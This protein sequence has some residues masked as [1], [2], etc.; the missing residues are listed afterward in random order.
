MKRWSTFA[1]LVF[2]LHFAWEMS[3]AAW[4]ASMRG[5]TF[6]R[7][8]FACARAALGDL[9]IVTI[10]F[11]VAAAVAKSA[12]WPMERRRPLAA[13]TFVLAGL[14]IVVAYEFF[15]LSSG[16]WRYAETMPTLIGIGA[17][18]LLQWLL[19]PIIDVLLF[20]LIFRRGTSGR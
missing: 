4:F 9:V 3:Q 8:T 18:P 1:T 7:G 6:W 5:L 10:A 2:A 17:L 19:L 12:S 16:R 11:A 14:S 15:A 13:I 20:R